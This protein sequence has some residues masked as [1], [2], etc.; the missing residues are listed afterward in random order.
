MKYS[1]L[2][3]NVYVEF[4]YR[5]IAGG[6]VIIT[7]KRRKTETSI[8]Y[9]FFIKKNIRVGYFFVSKKISSGK[10]YVVTINLSGIMPQSEL[11]IKL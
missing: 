7:R 1:K 9:N 8:K 6:E 3:Y 2:I 11:M 10:L 5:F 4:V